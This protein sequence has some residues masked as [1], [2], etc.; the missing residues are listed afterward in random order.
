ML[1][2]A[3]IGLM[4]TSHMWTKC[5]VCFAALLSPVQALQGTPIL[6]NLVDH[7]VSESMTGDSK[8]ACCQH[9]SPHAKS[10]QQACDA[11]DCGTDD[12][13]VAAPLSPNK[14]PQDCSCRRMA[15]PQ[16]KLSGST[17]L[18]VSVDLVELTL[19]QSVVL[20]GPLAD[21]ERSTARPPGS[22]ATAQETCA[23]LCRFLV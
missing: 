22:L 12:V 10:S 23:S 2:F 19:D 9:E 8:P 1:V 3:G 5:L 4:N 7:C 11:T 16:P 21:R 17:R 15:Q 13:A 6:C 14:C 20:Q 18:R